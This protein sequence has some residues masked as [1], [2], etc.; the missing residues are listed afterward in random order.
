MAPDAA[1]IIERRRLRRRLGLWRIL[2]ILA[3]MSAVAALAWRQLPA[4]AHLA[5]VELSGVIATDPARDAMLRD[6]SEDDSTQA[7]VLR[8]NSPGGTVAG[9][10]ALYQTLRRLAASKPLVVVMEE[11][12]ASGGYIAALGADRIFARGGTITGSIGVVMEFPVVEGLMNS[13]GVDMQRV[14]SSPL[15]AQPSPFRAPSDQVLDVQR[16][17]IADSYEW[18]VA[19]VAQRR[20]LPEARARMLGD[21]RIFSGRQALDA[22]LIDQLGGL[23]EARDWLERTHGIGR[24]L[25]LRRIEPA[26][27]NQGFLGRLIGREARALA[28]EAGMLEGMLAILR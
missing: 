8:I 14:A 21:G 19:L 17:L 4:V 16:L 15:K 12:A 7:V 1:G 26:R 10:E 20:N 28:R 11:V 13:L 9:S 3:V 2:A 27:D 18:F 24:D 25:P 22:G 23:A 6:L 5:E